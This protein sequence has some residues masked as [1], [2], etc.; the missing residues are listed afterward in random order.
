MQRGLVGSE[1]C[2]RDRVSTQS[3]WGYLN[4][5]AKPLKVFIASDHAGFELKEI[6][7]AY[8]KEK[9][10]EVEDLGPFEGKTPVNAKDTKIC[11]LTTQIMQKHW[12][13]R[14]QAL[15]AVREQQFAGLDWEFLSPAT[16]QRECAARSAMTIIQ[17]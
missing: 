5:E 7:K 10:Y 14:W 11:R 6:L 15:R 1:M 17:Q 4:M 2:I 9:K 16:R 12:E 8:M 3:T 13:Q